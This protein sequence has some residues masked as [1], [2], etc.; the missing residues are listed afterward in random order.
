MAPKPCVEVTFFNP[1]LLRNYLLLLYYDWLYLLSITKS[2]FW[3]FIGAVAIGINL[4]GLSFTQ[5]RTAFPA[6]ICGAI[7]YLFTTIRSSESILAQHR[8]IWSWTHVPLSQMTSEFDG[9]AGL[10][11]GR[12]RFNLEC[13]HGS[14]LNKIHGWGRASDLL[15]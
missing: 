4:F 10:F 8:R 7:I 1:E 5:N 6:I 9:N 14:S 3:K 12:T 2:W 13:R 15:A 11:H